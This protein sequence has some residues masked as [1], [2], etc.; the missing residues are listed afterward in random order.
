MF[1]YLFLCDRSGIKNKKKPFITNNNTSK[2]KYK[3]TCEM[4]L[5]VIYNNNERRVS[6]SSLVGINNNEEKNTNSNKILHILNN[7]NKIYSIDENNSYYY[8]NKIKNQKLRN[9]LLVNP[10]G[11]VKKKINLKDLFKDRN[12]ISLEKRVIKHNPNYKIF[13]SNNKKCQSNNKRINS[14]RPL[15]LDSNKSFKDLKELINIKQINNYYDSSSKILAFKENILVFDKNISL[16]N[17]NQNN[18]IIGQNNNISIN[19]NHIDFNNSLINQSKNKTKQKYQRPKSAT[20]GHLKPKN[21]LIINKYQSNN[22]SNYGN[23]FKDNFFIQLNP[24]KIFDDKYYDLSYVNNNNKKETDFINTFNNSKGKMM[25]KPVD[26][27]S[28]KIISFNEED[29]YIF[30]EGDDIKNIIIN[31]NRMKLSNKINRGHMFRKR[32]IPFY[33]E[34]YLNYLPKNIKKDIKN[35]YNF[36]SYL[37]TDNI[38]YNKNNIIKKNNFL[39]SKGTKKN[40]KNKKSNLEI[41]KNNIK[42]KYNLTEYNFNPKNIVQNYKLNC[43]KEEEFMSYLKQ[44]DYIEKHPPIQHKNISYNHISSNKSRYSKINNIYK[45]V[46][47]K[48]DSSTSNVIFQRNNDNKIDKKLGTSEEESEICEKIK[49]QPFKTKKSKYIK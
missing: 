41:Q 33:N 1:Q 44:L 48:V 46:K 5:G 2:R 21:N 25:I 28:E 17:L 24:N 8:N 26:N 6:T 18:D 16:L 22:I 12:N 10:M 34:K 29:K 47:I 31:F 3:K 7:N 37:L 42:I 4:K 19:N 9:E 14:A 15:I 30:S 38:Y 40:K 35:K 36:F 23:S 20:Y 11:K 32:P 27:S 39:K 43:R 45:P 49:S 13:N